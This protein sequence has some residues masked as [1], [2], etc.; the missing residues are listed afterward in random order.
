[1]KFIG[2]HLLYSVKLESGML[3]VDNSV[4]KT[5]SKPPYTPILPILDTYKSYSDRNKKEIRKFLVLVKSVMFNGV[6]RIIIIRRLHLH[7]EV[8]WWWK[9][10]KWN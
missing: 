7:N 2:Y 1:M 5:P 4:K 6:S 8:W 10:C 3:D 9:C